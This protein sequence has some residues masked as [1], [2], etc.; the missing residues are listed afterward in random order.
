MTESRKPGHA[1][2]RLRL[3]PPTP[4][5]LGQFCASQVGPTIVHSKLRGL[6]RRGAS[7]TYLFLIARRARRHE[8]LT[9]D[10]V[11]QLLRQYVELLEDRVYDFLADPEGHMR[12][13]RDEWRRA[14]SKSAISEIIARVARWWR[15][16]AGPTGAR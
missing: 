4:H 9:S 13:K 2:D 8:F 15:V 7:E 10:E 3:F 6:D 12:R 11:L 5:K 14:N 1:L 16:L